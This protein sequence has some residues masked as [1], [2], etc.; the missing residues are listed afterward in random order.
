MNAYASKISFS[1]KE[2]AETLGEAESTLRYWENEFSDVIAPKRNEGGTRFYSEKDIQDVKTVQFLLRYRKFTIE[3]ARKVLKN[4]K[5]AA[6][7]QAKLLKHL[8]HIHKEL[9]KFSKSFNSPTNP[10]P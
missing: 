5:E 6:Q 10:T 9:K 1:I 8:Q 2:V 4:N 7:K 3:G